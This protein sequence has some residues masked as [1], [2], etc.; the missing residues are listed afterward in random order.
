MKRMLLLA[1]AA[2]APAW[3]QFEL[4][5]VNGNIDQPVPRT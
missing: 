4:Y 3:G 5:L 2:A 1:L